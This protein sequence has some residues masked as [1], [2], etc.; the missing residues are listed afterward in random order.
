MKSGNNDIKLKKYKFCVLLTVNLKKVYTYN[1]IISISVSRKKFKMLLLNYC[2]LISLVHWGSA[3]EGLENE[4]EENN[5]NKNSL[6]AAVDAENIYLNEWTVHIPKG[7]DYANE[8]AQD[9]GLIN[10][11]EI[12]P[13][14]DHFHMKMPSMRAKR[15]IEPSHYIHKKIAEHPH[16]EQAE[17]LVAKV[18]NKRDNSLSSGIDPYWDKMW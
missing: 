12:I 9:H 5:N 4:E 6:N 17:Q 18:R 8:F 14:S 3:Q 10:L 15:S 13:D 11:G 1:S 2:F 16:V 7:I